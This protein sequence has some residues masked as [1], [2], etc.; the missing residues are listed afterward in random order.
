M[1]RSALAALVVVA[2]VPAALAGCRRSG[3]APASASASLTGAYDEEVT[4]TARVVSGL[5]P[6]SPGAFTSIVSLPDW[7][8]WESESRVRWAVALDE[9]LQPLR[10]WASES[11]ASEAGACQTLLQPFGGTEFL[12]AYSLFPSCEGYVL[13]GSESAGQL[14]AMNDLSSA[15]MASYFEDVRRAFPDVFTRST[16]RRQAAGSGPRLSGAIFR[17]LVQLARLDAKIVSAT[18][19]DITADGRPLE[20]IPVRGGN[21][22]PAAL[23]LTFEVPNGHPQSLVYF[24]ADVEDGALRRRPGAWTFLRMQAPFVTLL[25]PRPMQPAARCS[26]L[27]DLIVD[28]STMILQVEPGWTP[29]RAPEW[30]VRQLSPVP[31]GES[32][33]LP[34]P[35]LAVK[36]AAPGRGGARR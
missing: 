16:A 4:D 30:R 6:L 27:R 14:P 20:S 26:L 17:L 23:S 9:R 3:A 10:R 33:R 19:F 31:G 5:R 28:Q 2:L 24:P 25:A 29:L 32:E 22:R 11:L 18:R 15:Q 13:V 21:A 35:T 36:A 34:A 1:N 8:G 12:L 7:L